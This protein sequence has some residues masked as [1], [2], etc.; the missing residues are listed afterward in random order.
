[1]VRTRC[2]VGDYPRTSTMTRSVPVYLATLYL[3]ACLLSPPSL[4]PPNL[5]PHPLCGVPCM[6]RENRMNPM[7]HDQ[8]INARDFPPQKNGLSFSRG[9]KTM[10][11]FCYVSFHSISPPG[12]PFVGMKESQLSLPSACLI[13]QDNICT[14]SL[15]RFNYVFIQVLGIIL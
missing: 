6:D 15:S 9:K 3:V 11:S 2:S 5:R 7:T 12:L 1:M 13:L 14:L 10:D 8:K 4:P